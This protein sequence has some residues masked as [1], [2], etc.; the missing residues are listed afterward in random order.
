MVR[1]W[2]PFLSLHPIIRSEAKPASPPTRPNKNQN[3]ASRNYL[4]NSYRN[5]SSRNWG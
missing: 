5:F 3:M 4:K 2:H 1:L